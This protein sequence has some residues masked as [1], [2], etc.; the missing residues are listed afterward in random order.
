MNFLKTLQNLPKISLGETGLFQADGQT[1][2]MIQLLAA[3]LQMV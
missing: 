2:D 3:T 1:G